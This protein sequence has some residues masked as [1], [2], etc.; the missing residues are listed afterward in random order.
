MDLRL[1]AAIALTSLSGILSAQ[2]PAG[3]TPAQPAPAA[4]PQ[5]PD[6]PQKSTAEQVQ[7]LTRDKERI[8]KEIQFVKDRAAKSRD[9]LRE[10]FAGRALAPRST[11]AGTSA[12]AAP[13][14]V[15]QATIKRARIMTD[16]EA[17]QQ[18]EA[19]YIVDGRPVSRAQ[20]DAML[21]YLKTF[22]ASG[23]D[24]SRAQRATMEVIRIESM[25]AAVPDQ[26][27]QAKKLIEEAS[28][29]VAGGM[30]F[31]E[32]AKVYSSGPGLLQDG[33]VTIT[34]FSPLGLAVEA[35]AFQGKDGS[36]VGPLLSANGFVLVQI[37]K[38]V[39]G[40]TADADQVEARLIQVPFHPDPKEMEQIRQRASVGKIDVVARDQ[41]AMEMLPMYLRPPAS[42]APQQ[43]AN[44]QL[45][46]ADLSDED[47]KKA[48]LEAE[49]QFEQPVKIGGG[50]N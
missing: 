3:T 30:A 17:K 32:A 44:K 48:K 47:V 8:E 41:A 20:V 23:D 50:G 5:D 26:A 14:P 45:P 43:P 29:K 49:K 18:A 37:E 40:D 1:L 13:A 42:I 31:G 24:Q 16:A 15:A 27:S 28:A 19:M 21:T 35:A 6:R 34:H 12:I 10:K 7:D 2:V 22:P 11:D 9:V 25:L 33:K 36:V 4:K 39:K 46:K 38:H